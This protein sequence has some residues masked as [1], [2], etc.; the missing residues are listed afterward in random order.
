MTAMLDE[1]AGDPLAAVVAARRELRS[2]RER[3]KAILQQY[4]RRQDAQYG[5]RI[6]L[7]YEAG[8]PQ[9]DIVA[10]LGVKSRE[11]VARYERTYRRWM[12]EHPADDLSRDP[13]WNAILGE[14]GLLREAS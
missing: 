10:E 9:T 12:I 7:A 11:D 14:A 8:I 6:A 4:M 1:R 13:D 3:A 5:R 2:G